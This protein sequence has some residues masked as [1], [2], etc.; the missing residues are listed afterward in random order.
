[1]KTPTKDRRISLCE[2]VGLSELQADEKL[3]QQSPMPP[4]KFMQ[5]RANE[6]HNLNMFDS[7]LLSHNKSHGFQ[8]GLRPL[9]TPDNH[10]LIKEAMNITPPIRPD[11]SR[12]YNLEST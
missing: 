7:F 2:S 4:T 5:N 8:G 1:M 6:M 12:T 9:A 11:F 3:V 10:R